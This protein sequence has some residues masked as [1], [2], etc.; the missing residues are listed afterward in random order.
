MPFGYGY[1][2]F[3][4]HKNIKFKSKFNIKKTYNFNNAKYNISTSLKCIV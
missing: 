4:K 3:H 2:K 1:I